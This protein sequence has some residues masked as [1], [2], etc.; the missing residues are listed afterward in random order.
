MKEI[1]LI[2]PIKCNYSLRAHSMPGHLFL[3]LAAV[4]KLGK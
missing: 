3:I 1:V 4:K 2:I